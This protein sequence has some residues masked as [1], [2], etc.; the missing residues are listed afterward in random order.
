[1]REDGVRSL[2]LLF[3]TI[4]KTSVLVGNKEEKIRKREIKKAWKKWR[5]P[6]SG[7]DFSRLRIWIDQ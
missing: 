1:M 6:G 5:M 3:L 2:L 4:K 7:K